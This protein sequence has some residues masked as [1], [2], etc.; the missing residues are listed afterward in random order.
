MNRRSFSSKFL[1][2][3]LL[4]SYFSK[5]PW[6]AAAARPQVSNRPPR[7]G[8]YEIKVDNLTVHLDREGQIAAAD[9]GPRKLRRALSG[10]LVLEG[11]KSEGPVA[12]R[13]LESGGVEFSSELRSPDK[14]EFRVVQRFLPAQ[15][16]VRWEVEITSDGEP[17][18]VPITTKLRWPA[19]ERVRIWAPWVGGDDEWDDPLESQ[20][21]SKCYW[22]CTSAY[23]PYAGIGGFCI[24]MASF[25]EAEE[26][27][28]LSLVL[29]PEDSI[30]EL[31]L[32]TDA[33]GAVA[34]RRLDNRLGQGRTTNVAVD[35]VAHEADWRGG[36][37]WM[38]Q[39]YEP[40]FDPPNPKASKMAGTGAY[41]G[42]DG[43]ID[44]GRLKRM[45][46]SV[47][48]E[49]AFDWP[50]MGM[51]F[52]PLDESETWWSA[53]YNSVGDHIPELVKRLS[54]S[55]LNDR[56]RTRNKE[57]IYYLSYF[58]FDAWGWQDVYSI[59]VMDRN[60]PQEYWWTD[61]A[62]Y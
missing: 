29:S 33:E 61:P 39:R 58:N 34:F 3:G 51:Y 25:L 8:V 18:T 54:Y 17:W 35:L 7:A 23:G 15:G 22:P 13:R 50:Y 36:L 16:S 26:D 1:K 11:C 59:K 32:T 40:F 42:W 53:G 6:L 5:P 30:L 21:L 28:G 46:F 12:A 37:R 45:A 27:T 52:P 47:L 55:T 9:I 31:K 60:L 4:S 20:P 48:W 19:P 43:P 44:A 49:A 10:G 41:S 14:R 24:P 62:T 56:A 57:G 38:V 2:L